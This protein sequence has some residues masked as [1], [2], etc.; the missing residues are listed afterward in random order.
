LGNSFALG[1]QDPDAIFYHPGALTRIQGFTGSF[2]R[3]GRA[4]TFA[5]LSAG[6]SW[7]SGGVALGIQHLSYEPKPRASLPG[8]GF[9]GTPAD[10]AALREKGNMGASELV[11]SA[12]YGRTVKGVQVGLVGKIIEEHFGS[13]GGSVAAVDF[14]AAASPGPLEVGLSVQNLGS[15]LTVGGEDIPLP[16]RVSVGASTETAWVGPL[17]LSA[18][19]AVTYWEGG[20]LVPSAG[21][22]ISYWPVTGRT[23]F[24]RMGF[25]R[26]PDYHSGSPFTFGFGFRGDNILLD[27]AYEG[28]DS[29]SPTHRLGIGLR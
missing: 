2:Q 29:G 25:R 11:V 6:G 27:Y 4:S 14:G 18:S 16:L 26:L 28:F 15:S 23:F 9:L 7:L 24:G 5:S 21:V 10:P 3:Y 12:G 1:S 22:E 17:D 8:L 19:G 13:L 20:D